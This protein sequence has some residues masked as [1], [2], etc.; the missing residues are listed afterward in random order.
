MAGFRPMTIVRQLGSRSLTAKPATTFT[1]VGFFLTH[2]N[3]RLSSTLL[4]QVPGCP[5]GL[6]SSRDVLTEQPLK[7]FITGP[8]SSG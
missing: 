6:L 7:A 5:S 4:L 8:T 2:Y 3:R 1:P